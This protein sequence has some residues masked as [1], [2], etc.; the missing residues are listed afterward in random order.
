[1]GLFGGGLFGFST[2][3]EGA[4]GITDDDIRFYYSVNSGPG[5]D[6]PQPSPSLSLGGFVSH[7]A[8]PG[9]ENND[10]FGSVGSAQA[11]VGTSKYRCIFISNISTTYSTGPLTLTITDVSA[12][13][14]LRIGADPAGVVVSNRST[15]QAVTVANESTAPAGVTFVDA[16]EGISIPTLAPGR[17][18][19][20]LTAQR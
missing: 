14:D 1:M 9:T 18:I 8:W 4:S 13:Y 7:T 12:P 5:L 11:T 16:E 10:L 2:E 3:G 6:Y 20:I 19:V 17:S 15:A